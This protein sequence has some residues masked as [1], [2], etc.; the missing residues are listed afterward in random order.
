[1]PVVGA[2]DALQQA[3]DA[4]GRADLDHLVDAAPVDAEIERGGRHH[5]AQLPRRHR[6]LD[7]AALLDVEA[8]VMQRDRQVVGR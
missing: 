8:A 6:R 4:L 1:M 7:L 3:R 2:A 5:G